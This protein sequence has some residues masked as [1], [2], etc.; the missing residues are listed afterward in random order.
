MEALDKTLRHHGLFPHLGRMFCIATSEDE[1]ITSVAK[2]NVIVQDSWSQLNQSDS[3][4]G[5]L[6][7]FES[8][9][10][11]TT[12]EG[13][14]RWMS[15]FER[16]E[17]IFY[18]R[19]KLFGFNDFNH[20][21]EDLSQNIEMAAKHFFYPDLEEPADPEGMSRDEIIDHAI[22]FLTALSPHL[23]SDRTAQ[24][25]IRGLMTAGH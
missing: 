12:E 9:E 3:K 17:D 13:I 19:G 16:A 14:R 5:P 25:V 15:G 11:V 21:G 20:H 6:K 8:E 4:Y 22:E 7:V 24:N 1:V 18:D 23:A 10:D 2:L